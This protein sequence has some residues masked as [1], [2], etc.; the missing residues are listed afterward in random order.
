MKKQIESIINK[1]SN[2]KIVVLAHGPSLNLFIDNINKVDKNCVIIG[3]NNWH[4]FYNWHPDFWVLSNSELTI[5]KQYTKIN[6]FKST[7]LFYCD[8]VDLTDK[9]WVSEVLSNNYIPY[10]T[11]HINREKCGNSACCN[12]IEK[13]RLTIQEYLKNY[14]GY[15]ELYSAG[16]SVIVHQLA[17]AVL[18]GSDNIYVI[19]GDLDYTK[20]YAKNSKNSKPKNLDI[21]NHRDSI[22]NDIRIIN[23]SAKNKGSNIYTMNPNN[24]Y[25]VLDY[26]PLEEIFEKE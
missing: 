16:S 18:L 12:H 7:T 13:D 23:D 3:C 4:H 24:N 17:L 14:T 5:K 11:R 9:K 22:L 20:G 21:N 2:N 19:G 1:F 15:N 6:E 26:K 25:G 10:D 8:S